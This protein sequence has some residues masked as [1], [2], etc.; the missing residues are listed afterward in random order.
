[1]A[2]IAVTTRVPLDIGAIH[3]IGIGGIGMSG[4]AEIMHNLGYKVQGS[5]AAEN[6]N[7]KRLKKL[8]IAVQ[9]G[10]AAENLKDAHAVVY[11]SAVKPGNVEFDAARALSL[12]LVRRAEGAVEKSDENCRKKVATAQR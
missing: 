4:I 6:A 11:S 5:D 10:H 9:V 12:P 2:P 1:M 8:G 7:V 3:F